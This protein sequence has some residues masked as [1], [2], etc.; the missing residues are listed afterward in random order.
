MTLKELKDLI[1]DV[2]R[3]ARKEWD[4]EDSDFIDDLPI[5]AYGPSSEE[6]EMDLYPR[7]YLGYPYIEFTI[8]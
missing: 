3:R 5:K 4:L 2:E 6:L 1:S 8:E 7:T